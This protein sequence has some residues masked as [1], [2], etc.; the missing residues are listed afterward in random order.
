MNVTQSYMDI[1]HHAISNGRCY[2]MWFLTIEELLPLEVGSP[3]EWL[4]SP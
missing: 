4:K 2:A 3:E 1:P